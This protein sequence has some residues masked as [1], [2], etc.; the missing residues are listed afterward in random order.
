MEEYN[1]EYNVL[2][3]DDDVK[4]CRL[5][6]D[7]LLSMGFHTHI[8]HDGKEGIDNVRLNNFDIVILDVMLPT[9]DGFT[10]LTE[11]RTFSQVPVIMLTALGSETD[12]VLGLENGAD[13]YLSKPFTVRELLAR[14][15]ALIRRVKVAEGTYQINSNELKVGEIS[16]NSASRQVFRNGEEI[17]LT[18][19]EFDLLFCMMRLKGQILSRDRLLEEIAGRNSH[20]FDRSIDVHVSSLRKKLGDDPKNPEFIKT[21][22]SVGYVFA[23]EKEKYFV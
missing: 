5:V 15:R 10:V 6:K 20:I 14:L 22:R 1:T 2:M 17:I 4:L 7:Y 9:L 8:V 16:I 3:I 21:I 12:R 11:I 19:L 13:D 18:A 23:R